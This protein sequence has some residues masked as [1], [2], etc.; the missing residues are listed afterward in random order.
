MLV[1]A[2]TATGLL[3]IKNED[4]PEPKLVIADLDKTNVWLEKARAEWSSDRMRRAAATFV[5]LPPE[6]T[7]EEIMPH[8]REAR[9][10]ARAR[11][12]RRPPQRH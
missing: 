5:N 9:N 7:W 4:G 10:S 8:Y 11:A 3:P 6:S 1:E 2:I 12:R